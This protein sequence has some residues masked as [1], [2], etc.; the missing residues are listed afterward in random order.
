MIDGDGAV[1]VLLSNRIRT[2][3]GRE[4]L[5]QSASISFVNAEGKI[6]RSEAYYDPHE[7]QRDAFLREHLAMYD[8]VV[9]K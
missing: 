6:Y 2:Q 9:S 1:T 7:Q 3:D 5:H 8:G 4:F